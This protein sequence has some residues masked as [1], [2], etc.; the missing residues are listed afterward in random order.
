MFNVHI[1]LPVP[2]GTI[3]HHFSSFATHILH[4]TKYGISNLDDISCHYN[5]PAPAQRLL[6]PQC[7][8]SKTQQIHRSK[9]GYRIILYLVTK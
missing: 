3:L 7:L 2:H 6:L 4:H 5:H 9:Q 1:K 8:H